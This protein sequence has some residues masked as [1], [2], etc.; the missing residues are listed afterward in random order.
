MN[1]RQACSRGVRV[2]SVGIGISGLYSL[3]IRLSRASKFHGSSAKVVSELL[4][5]LSFVD[6]R[7]PVAR[8]VEKREGRGRVARERRCL[9]PLVAQV[10]CFQIVTVQIDDTKNNV[11]T[12]L[13]SENDEEF[14]FGRP[15]DRGK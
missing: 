4:S 10:K 1:S 8:S 14:V 15:D 13:L 7:C 9:G 2:C 3:F 6:D 5:S 11:R 12:A